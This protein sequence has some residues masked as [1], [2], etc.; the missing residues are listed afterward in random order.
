MRKFKIRIG[1]KVGSSALVGVV[2]VAGMV[3]N[4]TRVSG[5]TQDLISQAALSRNLQQAG[6]RVVAFMGAHPELVVGVNLD[7]DTYLNPFYNEQQWYD[8]NPGTLRQFRE[9]LAGTGPYAGRH[10]KDVPDLSR[11]RRARPPSGRTQ[12]A[13]A[14]PRSDA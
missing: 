13:R 6:R 7:P 2:L 5:L 12:P 1:T 10:D 14:C 11:Y 8:Y 4:Q 9:W 3:W